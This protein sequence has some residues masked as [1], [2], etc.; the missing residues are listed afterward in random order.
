MVPASRYRMSVQYGGR[1][2]SHTLLRFMNL[3]HNTSSTSNKNLYFISFVTQPLTIFC[4]GHRCLYI[5]T[6]RVVHMKMM[7]SSSDDWILLA[8]WLQLLVITLAYSAITIT[9]ALGFSVSTSR[10]LA[11]GLT[12]VSLTALVHYKSS[13]AVRIY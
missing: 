7:G 10:L 13:S 6:C 3:W 5:V 1:Y 11:T 4:C 2:S 12:T 8:F 9:H